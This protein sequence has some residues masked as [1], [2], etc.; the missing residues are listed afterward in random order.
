MQTHSVLS[1]CTAQPLLPSR[2]LQ[3]QRRQP[4]EHNTR[5]ACSLHTQPSN[6]RSHTVILCVTRDNHAYKACWAQRDTPCPCPGLLCFTVSSRDLPQIPAAS[7]PPVCTHS[8]RPLG[9]HR[10]A[11]THSIIVI[12]LDTMTNSQ[13]AN[14]P[15]HEVNTQTQT[16][17][18]SLLCTHQ[19]LVTN[20]CCLVVFPRAYTNNAVVPPPTP[21]LTNQQ[22]STH[23]ASPV[24][25]E[26]NTDSYQSL[27]TCPPRRLHTQAHPR[28][29]PA[30]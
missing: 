27:P 20:S 13:G 4:Q 9:T 23:T 30:V 5:V 24:H 18:L 12:L 26:A 16:R 28:R 6:R 11:Q 22:N 7:I 10:G 25:T 29:D 15:R 1:P 3:P 17:M 14:T 8:H 21:G 2:L 19:F